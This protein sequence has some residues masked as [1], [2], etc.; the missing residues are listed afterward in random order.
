MEQTICQVGGSLGA[1]TATSHAMW[2]AGCP[3]S[4][5]LIERGGGPKA[6][7]GM[8]FAIGPTRWM[9]VLIVRH[10]ALRRA[11]DKPIKNT[12]RQRQPLN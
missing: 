12:R 6:G 1:A 11:R 5:G 4:S 3:C 10:S 8:P 2:V 9:F 7:R